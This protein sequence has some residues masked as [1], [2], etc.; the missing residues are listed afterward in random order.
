MRIVIIG[1]SGAGK[2]TLARD[3]DRTLGLPHVE[4]DALHWGPEWTPVSLDLFRERA[5]AA[6]RDEAWVVDGNYAPVRDIVWPRASHV[7]WLNFSLPTVFW[8]VGCRS[9][10]RWARRETLWAGNRESLA[11]TLFSRE[12]ILL[13]TLQTHAK[14]RRDFAA[15][16][17]SGAYP[18]LIWLEFQRPRDL[19]A[20]LGQQRPPG[21]GPT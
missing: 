3:L 16:R 12:S 5:D 10:R 21:A 9:W 6:T 14:R 18:H 17:A 4:L 1:T 2:S 15:L 19:A 20:W 7:I 11:R 8:R 13:W